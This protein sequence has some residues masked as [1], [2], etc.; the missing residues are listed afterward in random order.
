M[1][2]FAHRFNSIFLCFRGWICLVF[3]AALEYCCDVAAGHTGMILLVL[4]F[5]D[6]TAMLHYAEHGSGDGLR[7]VP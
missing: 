4:C 7:S 5:I 6:S 3:G 1:A 2:I